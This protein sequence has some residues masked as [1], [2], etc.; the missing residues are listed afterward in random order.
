MDN[1][2]ITGATGFIGSQLVRDLAMSKHKVVA[3]ARKT[4]NVEHLGNLG[5]DTHY[6][7][8]TNLRSLLEVCREVDIVIHLAAST[9]S[10]GTDYAKS[11]VVNVV[12]S[13][14]V[15]DACKINQ[16]RRIIYMG[17]QSD[18]PGA[19]ATTKREAEKLFRDS[20]LNITIIKPSLVY[21]PG[22]KG[23]FG[24]M[25]KFIKKLPIIPIVGSGK[26]PMKPIYVGDVT[27]AIT[28]CLERD[29]LKTEYF[30]S[31]STEVTYGQL[32]DAIAK[33]MGLRRG[34]VRI[35]HFLTFI[36]VS[37]VSIFLKSF[38][39]TVDTLRGLVNPRV[40]DSEDAE[41]DLDFRP[42]PLE[43]GMERT[44]AQIEG[45]R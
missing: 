14:N 4:S 21:G 26:Y 11:F 34:K 12:G 9:S 40:Y 18:N 38:P 8:V 20:G 30:I 29:N 24:S 27:Q 42:L 43:Q 19:Y 22:G 13:Q 17:T 37:F 25:A 45:D 31:G 5:I 36:G 1:I 3:L 16:V 39:I 35:P 6:G 15:I 41:R 32:M 44:F 7:D 10:E 28:S 33:A 23:L 2:L